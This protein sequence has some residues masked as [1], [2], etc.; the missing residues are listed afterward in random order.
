MVA[1]IRAV[2]VAGSANAFLRTPTKFADGYHQRLLQQ[3]AL[4]HIADKSRQALI[5]HRSGLVPHPFRQIL[6]MIPRMIVGVGYLGPNDFHHA[7]PS[8]NQSSSQQA[9]LAES[10][11]SITLAHFF[12]LLGEIKRVS[13][14]TGNN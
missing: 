1:P 11:L 2:L 9:T 6:V 5:E 12:R 7:S 14:A 8:F 3:A 10:I 4:I 13:D